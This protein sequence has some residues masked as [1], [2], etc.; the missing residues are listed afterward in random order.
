MSTLAL[1]FWI[2]AGILFLLAAF[3]VAFRA[4]LGW[5]GAAAVVVAV[6]VEHM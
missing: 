1:V 6:L 2:I 4:H 5:L 3:G